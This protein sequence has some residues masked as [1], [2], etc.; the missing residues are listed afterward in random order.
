M[1]LKSKFLYKFTFIF[2]LI[3]S[4]LLLY[5]FQQSS[6]NQGAN[7]SYINPEPVRQVSSKSK[8]NKP[9]ETSPISKLSTICCTESQSKSLKHQYHL[10]V[11]Q[12]FGLKDTVD[13]E[14]KIHEL[15]STL[16]LDMRQIQW[17]AKMVANPESIRVH[18]PE[19]HAEVRVFNLR[20][21][22]YLA[23]QGHVDIVRNTVL[24]LSDYL[25]NNIKIGISLNQSNLLDLEELSISLSKVYRKHWDENTEYIDLCVDLPVCGGFDSIIT[26]VVMQPAYDYYFVRYG[27]K[28]ANQTLKPLITRIRKTAR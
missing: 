4:C 15:F 2:C 26:E 5:V 16:M 28:K 12:Y 7:L 20:F 9:K 24:K 10:Q 6:Q 22:D 8:N 13:R 19:N 11:I 18:Y 23:T 25:Q 1:I 14:S 21:L 17:A 27:L 3:L